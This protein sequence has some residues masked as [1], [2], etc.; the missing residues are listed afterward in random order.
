MI[1]RPRRTAPASLVALVV[2]AV[3]AAVTVAVVQS[4]LG[5]TPFVSLSALLALTSGL[6]WNSPATVAAAVV[7][8]VIGLVL[9]A[10]A[11]RPGRPTVLPLGAATGPD[12]RP[13]A[14]T[15]VRRRSL[16][17]DLAATAAAVPGVTAADVSARRHRITARVRVA[18]ADPAAVPAQVRERL[19]ARIA[20]IGPATRPDL[21]V[22]ARPD[23]R[24]S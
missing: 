7:L 4:L 13:G 24:T 11:L 14:S 21:R 9:L 6:Q 5:R 22:R 16:A 18:A 10:A 20:E 2:L 15:G 19:W 3:C 17:G 8:A 23:R 12:G 1:R